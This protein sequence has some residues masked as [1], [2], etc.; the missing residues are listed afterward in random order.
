M[1]RSLPVY[2]FF[3]GFILSLVV[4]PLFL[5]AAFLSELNEVAMH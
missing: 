3:K 1:P 5:K 2:L 4:L